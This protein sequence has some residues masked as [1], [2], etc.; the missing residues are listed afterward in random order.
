MQMVR[1]LKLDNTQRANAT[2]FHRFRRKKVEPLV[3][4]TIT[5]TLPQSPH[6]QHTGGFATVRDVHRNST[7]TS[8]LSSY[9]VPTDNARS[10]SVERRRRERSAEPHADPLGL[11]V[12]YQPDESTPAVNIVFVHGLGGT[13]QK[14]WCRNRD[15]EYFWPREWLPLEKGISQARILSFGYNAHFASSGRENILNITDFAKDL[16]FGMRFGL[17]SDSQELEIGKVPTVFV[18]HSM[19]GLVVKKAY[20]LAQ[21]DAHYEEIMGS[22]RAI[23]FLSTP[24][25]GTNL[26]ELLNRI[27]S[28]S[29]FN[30]S[31]KHYIAELKQNSPAL[32]DI[33]EQ[34]RNL[35]PHLEIFSFFETQQT[36]VGPRKMMVLEKDSS[37]LGYPYEVSKPLD[38][39]HHNV[40][41]FTDQQDPNYISVRNAIRSVVPKTKLVENDIQPSQDNVDMSKV[42]T[43]L[44]ISCAPEDDLEYFRSLWMLGSCEWILSRSALRTW[45]GDHSTRSRIVFVNGLPGSGK[46]VLSSFIIG[47]LQELHHGCQYYFFRFGDHSKRSV[48]LMLRSL[49]YQ[50]AYQ[51]PEVRTEFERL[52]DDAVR[53]EKAEVRTS[54]QK[55]F[56]SRL[57]K[58]RLQ[59]PLYWVIDALDECEAPEKVLNLISSITQSATPLRVMFVGRKTQALSTAFQR[60]EPLIEVNYLPADGTKEDLEVYVA[61]ETEYMRGGPQIKDRVIRTVCEMACGNF[62]WVRLVLKEILQCHTEAEIH[63]ALS[64]LPPDLELLYQRMAKALAETSRAGDRALSKKIMTWVVCSQR[65][66]SMNELSEA[67]Q[68]E[69]NVLDL[70]LTINQICGDFVVVDSKGRIEMMHQTARDYLVRTPGLEQ[71]ITPRSGHQDLFLR[72]I[73]YLSAPQ[74]RTK[75]QRLSAPL[76]GNYAGTCWPYHLGLSG[77]S[78]DHTVLLSLT[79]FFQGSCVLAWIQLLAQQNHLQT[80]VFASQNLM[81]YLGKK[82]KVDAESSPLTHRLQEKELLELWAIDLVKV[83]GKFGAQLVKYSKSIH[84]LVP[85]LCPSTSAICQQFGRG[86]TNQ[87]ILVGGFSRQRW[88]DCLSK[89][90][91]GRD[92][93]AL[94]IVCLD[95]YFVILTS[96]GT[97]WL[98]DTI[99]GQPSKHIVHGERVLT[100]KFSASSEKCV[101]YGLRST[102]VWQVHDTHQL[103]SIANP[104]NAKAVDVVFA[105]NESTIITCSDDRRVRRCHLESPAKRWQTLDMKIESDGADGRQFNS[106]RRVAFNA[107]GTQLAVAFRGFPL[108]VWDVDSA[109]LVGRCERISDKN[110]S[111]QD[112]HTDVG[113]ICWNPVTGH[114]LGLY[115]DGCVF[116]WHPSETDSQE[117]RTVAT[118]IQCS[119]GGA[120][121]VTNSTN[122]VLKVWDFHHFSLVY[123][124]SCHAPVTDLEL[125]P[126]GRR[127]YDIR[128]TFCNI[129]EPN[130]LIRLAEADEKSS[131]TSSTTA[132]STQLSLSSEAS[133]EVQE[134]LTA[135]SVGAR[136]FSFCSGD[137]V[138]VVR[139]HMADA[140]SSQQIA[141]GFMP[142]D[143]V[144][145]SQ[146]ERYLV[147]AD[148]GGRLNVRQ[149]DS[150]SPGISYPLVL[151]TKSGNGLQQILV[152]PDSIYMLV[153]TVTLVELWSLTSKAVITTVSN[154]NSFSRWINHPL[155]RSMLV[156]VSSTGLRVLQWADLTQKATF[157]LSRD[158]NRKSVEGSHPEASKLPS[159]YFPMSPDEDLDAVDQVIV[160]NI[161]S[162]LIVQTSSPSGQR[163]R[164]VQYLMIDARKLL[165]LHG[166]SGGTGVATAHALPSAV[167]TR[168]QHIL[169]FAIKH[170][171]R[172]SHGLIDQANSAIEE[173]LTFIDHDDWVCSWLVEDQRIK[174]QRHFFLPQDWLSSDNLRLATVSREGTL[175]YPRNGEVAVISNWLQHEWIE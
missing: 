53:F 97:L 171:R 87:T 148:L 90:S 36:A 139:L 94:R 59:K 96:E 8:N 173:V 16:L 4:P 154:T 23:L 135:L 114:I 127:I 142:V 12:L 89:F 54:W 21:H 47:H 118:G 42:G 149:V 24:H 153:S 122:G 131:D 28:V 140:E 32:Q 152:S 146:D 125:S 76:F 55:L 138:G 143:H 132:D 52:A 67:L 71:S 79:R 70:R 20:I 155:D 144:V 57:F 61:K 7:T 11:T 14:T 107:D 5:E 115:N 62:L 69:H 124:L 75:L 92:R 161:R 130:A 151:E 109:D 95:R 93:Q 9:N 38:A 34:F 43:M 84:D 158:T 74:R 175:F 58:L 117:I 116:K 80:L 35:A 10:G 101:T 49:A 163:Q 18:A 6:Q 77:A 86:K 37:I 85:A 15:T 134:P 66:L 156:Q 30:H 82:A 99:T 103:C 64:E 27:L 174:V 126:D 33:N 25:R 100:F 45:L 162:H 133:N 98:Y 44:A 19:G 110:N 40:C 172:R 2:Q 136:T 3:I 123:Q 160:S 145:W 121:F 1:P 106:P 147:T 104:N 129:W 159:A 51:F 22:T 164:T 113:P 68:P 141:Q 137:E 17:G 165:I 50:I 112:L 128:D 78:S 46:S 72:C 60:M 157:T 29:V 120:L 150:L 166:D 169:G 73:S 105:N 26:A 81:S 91:I 56:T 88:D 119:S 170:P 65:P 111:R 102:K 63:Q 13:S 83:V 41:K 168:V 31:T 108:M 48:G 167:A 39:D